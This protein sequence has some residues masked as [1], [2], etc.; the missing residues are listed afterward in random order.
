MRTE[1]TNV[2]AYTINDPLSKHG[3]GSIQLMTKNAMRSRWLNMIVLD[4]KRSKAMR[5]SQFAYQQKQHLY[6]NELQRI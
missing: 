5:R 6:M 2:R 4:D 1:M 3:E